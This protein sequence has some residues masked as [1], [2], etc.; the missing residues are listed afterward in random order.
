M[1]LYKTT[2]SHAFKTDHS[3]QRRWVDSDRTDMKEENGTFYREQG[4]NAEHEKALTTFN[5]QI[6]FLAHSGAS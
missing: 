2:S 3:N 1:S 6:K 4:K 5:A